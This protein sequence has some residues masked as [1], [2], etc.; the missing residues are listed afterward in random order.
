MGPGSRGRIPGD[1]TVVP[2][3]EVGVARV[4][5]DDGGESAGRS[6]RWGDGGGGHGVGR[7]LRKLRPRRIPAVGVRRGEQQAGQKNGGR[8]RAGF[9]GF[10]HVGQPVRRSGCRLGAKPYGP[11][12][13]R[14]NRGGVLAIT[15]PASAGSGG[16]RRPSP[17]VDTSTP[18]AESAEVRRVETRPEQSAAHLPEATG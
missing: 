4:Q 5:P 1:V 13:R 16:L 17:H 10:G 18:Q 7:R 9:H 6:S 8:R 15:L 11:A 14:G 3:R 2:H 12:S